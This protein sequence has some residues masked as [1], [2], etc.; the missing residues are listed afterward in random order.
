VPNARIFLIL[1]QTFYLEY[2]E[3]QKGR[4]GSYCNF[5]ST[6]VSPTVPLLI[7]TV[8]AVTDPTP[9]DSRI[10]PLFYSTQQ[11]F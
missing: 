11:D 1:C 3:M 10:H 7:L 5:F 4:G 6:E 2:A 8:E 9:K